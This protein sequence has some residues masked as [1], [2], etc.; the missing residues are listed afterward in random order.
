MV[1]AAGHNGAVVL[2]CW[3]GDKFRRGVEEFYKQNPKLCGVVLDEHCD[4][5]AANLLVP[6]TGYSSHW[7]REEELRALFAPHASEVDVEIRTFGIGIFAI[8]HRR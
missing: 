8:A 7:W 1:S 2:G 6:D 5:E 4:F 3:W